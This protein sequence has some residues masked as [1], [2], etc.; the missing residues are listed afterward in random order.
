M[1]VFLGTGR[2][3]LC[4]KHFIAIYIAYFHYES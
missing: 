3:P 1:E 2:T 4:L